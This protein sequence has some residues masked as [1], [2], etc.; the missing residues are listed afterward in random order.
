MIHTR[1]F[2]NKIESIQILDPKDYAWFGIAPQKEEVVEIMVDGW[3]P[4][5]LFCGV[6]GRQFDDQTELAKKHGFLLGNGNKGS[7]TGYVLKSKSKAMIKA[8]K[9]WAEAENK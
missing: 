5:E 1:K 2:T 3:F 7:M 6:T 4:T 8:L 9:A